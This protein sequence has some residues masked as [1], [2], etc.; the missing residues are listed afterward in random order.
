MLIS[1]LVIGIV[2]F[3]KGQ[4]FAKFFLIGWLGFV[5]TTVLWMLCLGGVIPYNFITSQIQIL[6]LLF[7]TLFLT[8]ALLDRYNLLRKRVAAAN[9][10]L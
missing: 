4:Y 3:L 6:G 10:K 5:L 8:F 7:Q 2:C 1:V 9:N